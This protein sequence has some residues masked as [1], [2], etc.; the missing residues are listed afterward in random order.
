MSWR[1]HPSASRV[2][3]D[4]CTGESFLCYNKETAEELVEYLNNKYGDE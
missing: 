4:T 1:V 3:E 2:A